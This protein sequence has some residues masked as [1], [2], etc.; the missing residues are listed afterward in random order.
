MFLFPSV[1]VEK[2]K[3]NNVPV[4]LADGLCAFVDSLPSLAGLPTHLT[5]LEM[6]SWGPGL[7]SSSP[8]QWACTH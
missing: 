3:L 6:Q 5:S 2:Q 4:Y 1:T 8:W 7:S